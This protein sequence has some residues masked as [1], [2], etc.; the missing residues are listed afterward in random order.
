MRILHILLLSLL[1][2]AVCS[3]QVKMNPAVGTQTEVSQTLS[4]VTGYPRNSH[5]PILFAWWMD[6]VGTTID[7]KNAFTR[8]MDGWCLF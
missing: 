4:K 5:V 1:L 2:T 6:T 3:S 8:I 7:Y